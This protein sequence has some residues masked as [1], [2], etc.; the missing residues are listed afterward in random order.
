MSTDNKENGSGSKNFEDSLKETGREV[1]DYLRGA[2][3]KIGGYIK[4]TSKKIEDHIKHLVTF[5]DEKG[6]ETITPDDGN[7]KEAEVQSDDA[8]N[9]NEKSKARAVSQEKVPEQTIEI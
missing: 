5:E 7:L 6:D 4:D 2:G 1:E 8:T 3:E 9:L